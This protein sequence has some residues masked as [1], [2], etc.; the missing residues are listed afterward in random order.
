[1][2]TARNSKTYAIVGGTSG[3]GFALAE[4]LVARGDRVLLGGRSRDKADAAVRK[5]GA[6][7]TARTVD[8]RDRASIAAFFQGFFQGSS[9]GQEG[10]GTLA[11][12]FTPGSVNHSVSFREDT[13]EQAE[14]V[15]QAKFWGQYW[16]VHAALPYLAADASVVLMSG[17]ASVRPI[18]APA[19]AACNA[20]VEGLARALALELAPIRV[21]CVS[22]GTIDSELW[23][24]KPPEV[25]HAVGQ[26]WQKLTLNRRLGTVQEA[27]G[28]ALFLLD[29]GN[30]NGASI[31]VDGGYALR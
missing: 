14:A 21:N 25:Y 22:P 8:A 20:A 13:Q 5:L 27:A 4:Q 19:Y 11:G 28:A 2:S 12:L 15:F 3:M 29:N 17:A 30:M 1:M 31:Y 23:R 24:N 26:A 6:L 10:G 18:G 9:H 16:T 7:A